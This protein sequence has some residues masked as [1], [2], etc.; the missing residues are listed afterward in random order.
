MKTIISLIFLLTSVSCNKHDMDME[1]ISEDVLK[2][3]RGIKIE[4]NPVEES[5]DSK[6]E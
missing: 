6:T 1:G 3:K 2:S 5:K 4:I